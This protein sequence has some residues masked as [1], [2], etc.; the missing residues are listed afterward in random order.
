MLDVIMRQLKI[1]DDEAT[2]FLQFQMPL[3]LCQ[4]ISCP[5]MVFVRPTKPPH[6]LSWIDRI[7]P[8]KWRQVM[9]WVWLVL[10]SVNFLFIPMASVVHTWIGL[11]NVFLSQ[12]TG[13][14]ILI[15]LI[16]AIM[17]VYWVPKVTKKICVEM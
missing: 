13:Q 5:I 4:L 7:S 6:T 3:A 14:L 17:L 8:I 1:T 15:A 16:N 2:S 11:N 12:F 10:A 9:P